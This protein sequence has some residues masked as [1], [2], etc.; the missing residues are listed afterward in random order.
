M[1]MSSLSAVVPVLCVLALATAACSGSGSGSGSPLSPSTPS[2]SAAASAPASTPSDA[3]QSAVSAN[4]VEVTARITAAGAGTI[5]LGSLNLTIA[6]PATTVITRGA[7][8]K[9]VADLTVGLLVEVKAVRSGTIVTAT[10]VNIEDETPGSGT[11][12]E[13][14]TGEDLELTGTLT[15]RPA[16][17]CPAVTFTLGGTTVTT[18]AATRFDDLTCAS[19]AA[20]DA[21]RVEG[22]RQA[23][24]SV[25]ASEVNR[26]TGVASD[27]DA[28]DDNDDNDDHDDHDDHSRQ[29]VDM[30]GSLSVR[31]AGS[32][33]VVTFTL[34]GATVATS[35]ATR[36]DDVSCASLTTGDVLRVKGLRQSNGSIA[37]SEVTKTISSSGSGSNSGSGSS[38]SNSGRGSSGS[39]SGR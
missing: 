35:G 10:R 34:N 14:E 9:T 13:V 8:A 15:A 7:T 33:P 16:G 38:G 26:S 2:P 37:A 39:G 28:D 32:C 20:G 36:F 25:L 5:T 30:T 24:G 4:E 12:T 1:R 21:L 18:T 6:V 17:T 11:G 29:E 19:L 31:P 23:N 22:V 27:D 3:S